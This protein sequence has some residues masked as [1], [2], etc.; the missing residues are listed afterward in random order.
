MYCV[1]CRH[2]K[3][4]R[5]DFINTYSTAEDAVCKI[6]SCYNIDER[7]GQLGDYYYFMKQR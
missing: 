3:S 5:E 4:G 6:R 1:Y 7:I 2:I